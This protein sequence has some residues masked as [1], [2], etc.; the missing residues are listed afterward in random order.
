MPIQFSLE[1]G[2]I[3]AFEISGTLGRD[4][5]ELAQN[6]CEAAI[7]KVG[8]IKILAILKNFQGWEKASG[9]ED[10]SFAE[11]NDTY[12]DKIAIVGEK[13]WEDLVYAFTAKGLRPVAIEYFDASQQD[14]ARQWLNNDS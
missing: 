6:E 3:G 4:E 14:V 1:D 2:N 8:S 5:F 10:L 13:Q 9:W 7:H 11:R 12:I